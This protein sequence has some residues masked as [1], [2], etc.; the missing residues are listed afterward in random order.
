MSFVLQKFIELTNELFS[1]HATA[2]KEMLNHLESNGMNS[3]FM[4]SYTRDLCVQEE[5]LRH[6]PFT[7]EW[8]QGEECAALSDSALLEMFER[9]LLNL[10]KS[11]EAKVCRIYDPLVAHEAMGIQESIAK[12]KTLIKVAKR[13]I[14]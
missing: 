14:D 7:K 9:T 12:F 4:P 2:K 11:Q 3:T 1:A 6:Y 8:V 13:H 10:T 5:A